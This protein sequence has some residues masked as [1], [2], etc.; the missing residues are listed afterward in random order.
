M[1]EGVDITCG[2]LDLEDAWHG[3]ASLVWRMHGWHGNGT[4]SRSQAFI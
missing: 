1:T 3:M 2:R 4:G